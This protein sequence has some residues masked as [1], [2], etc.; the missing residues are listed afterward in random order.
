MDITK[1]STES[2]NPE[3]TN[4]DEMSAEEI[5]SVMN[6]E[7][8]KV[9]LAVEKVLPEISSA[10]NK[11]AESFKKDGR[12]F[13]VGAGTS[14]RLG[15]L[16]AAECVPTFGSDPE[17]VQGL[18]A[19][20]NKAMTLAVEGAEDDAELGASDLRDKNLSAKDVVVG[21]AASGR[22]PYVVGAL[23]YAKADGET[24]LVAF[25]EDLINKNSIH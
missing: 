5:V 8:K 20:G 23:D 22:T 18:I 25:L 17:M 3:T 4:L 11:I 6:E 9:P 19:G 7:D 16:D 10:A 12:L 15:V 13:Y 24:E 21:I 14:G 2:R 1:L